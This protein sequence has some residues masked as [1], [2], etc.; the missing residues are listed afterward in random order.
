VESFLLHILMV[1]PCVPNVSL[2]AISILAFRLWPEMMSTI[3]FV[4]NAMK[5]IENLCHVGQ[6]LVESPIS[7]LNPQNS[8]P[9]LR[10][11]GCLVFPLLEVVRPSVISNMTYTIDSK[12]EAPVRGSISGWES[13]YYT[14]SVSSQPYGRRVFST[15]E[16]WLLFCLQTKGQ[17]I[18]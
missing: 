14:A 17:V 1:R 12:P 11:R 2:S 18:Q 8:I 15:E 7:W 6:G 3:L 5:P 9:E 4:S 16:L 13:I 10:P